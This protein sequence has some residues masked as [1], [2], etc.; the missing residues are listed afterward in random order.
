M[1]L[2]Y[3][4]VKQRHSLGLSPANQCACFLR[5]GD[6]LRE[7]QA[8]LCEAVRAGTHTCS[9]R[10]PPAVVAED[11]SAPGRTKRILR[12][13]SECLGHGAL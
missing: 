7:G 13:L 10:E 6:R 12:T 9:Y 3:A 1:W 5:R 4:C 11:E 2:T 8:A